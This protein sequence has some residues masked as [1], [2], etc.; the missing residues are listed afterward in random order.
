MDAYNDLIVALLDGLGLGVARESLFLFHAE[1]QLA[2]S[3]LSQDEIEQRKSTAG[4][5]AAMVESGVPAEIVADCVLDAIAK[6]RFYVITH[7]EQIGAVKK[8][9]DAILRAAT[10]AGEFLESRRSRT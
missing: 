4:M 2:E 1:G 6:R 8:R 9:T 5:T 7:P 3:G 10:E